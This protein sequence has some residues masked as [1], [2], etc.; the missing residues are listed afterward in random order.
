MLGNLMFVGKQHYSVGC[1]GFVELIFVAAMY[2]G[3]FLDM[4]TY[5]C[6]LYY[7]LS[8]IVGGS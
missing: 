4:V 7:C 3:L 2:G 6:D 5:P 8:H 1:D